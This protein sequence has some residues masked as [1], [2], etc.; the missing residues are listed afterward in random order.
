MRSLSRF[1]S[2]AIWLAFLVFP[3][4]AQT[5]P[6]S[7]PLCIYDS[8]DYSDGAFI[9]VQKSLML[10]C[11][12]DGTK[13][14]WKIVDDKDINARCIAPLARTAEPASRPRYRRTAM[15]PPVFRAGDPNAKCFN[16]NGKRY[17]E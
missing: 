13:A 9:C 12:A 14:T 15:R 10:N 6:A 11:S 5:Q 1:F 8:K 7:A 4:A 17:C 2:L 16:F 3:A